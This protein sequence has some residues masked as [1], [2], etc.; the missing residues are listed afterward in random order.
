MTIS[1]PS[2]SSVAA[3]L[4]SLLAVKSAL[5]AARKPPPS[6]A[7]LQ[8]IALGKSYTMQ[9]PPNYRLCTDAGDTVQ[10][11]DGRKIGPDI[12]GKGQQPWVQEAMVGWSRRPEPISITLDLEKEEAISGISFRAAAGGGSITWP[13]Q[14]A[15]FVGQDGEN[16]HFLGD[17]C[18]MSDRVKSA[19]SDGGGF[20]EPVQHEFVTRELQTHA[21]YV[22]LVMAGS[23]FLFC[24]EIEVY[25]GDPDW[26]A[27]PLAGP[28]LKGDAAVKDIV[29]QRRTRAGYESRLSSDRHQ[30]EAGVA[31]SSLP[32][33]EKKRLNAQIAQGY[34]DAMAKELP[35]DDKFR[36]VIPLN[37]AHAAMH[38][39]RGRLWQERVG[40]MTVIEKPHR[41]QWIDFEHQPERAKQTN[42]ALEM[43]GGEFRSEMLLLSNPS[44]AAREVKIEVDGIQGS[45]G[46]LRV[47]SVPWTDTLERT[48]VPTALEQIDFTENQGV[49]SLPAG[50]AT[51]LWLMVDS[52]KL[53]AGKHSGTL[54]LSDAS[55]RQTVPFEVRVSSLVMPKPPMDFYLWDYSAGDPL[56]YGLT[57]NNLAPSI[58]LMREYHVNAPWSAQK[59]FPK[60]TAE[61]FDDQNRLK[62]PLDTSAM[63]QW[64]TKVWPGADRY[65]H[66]MGIDV[67]SKK[68]PTF[69]GVK[70]GDPAFEP[71]IAA[72]LQAITAR[73]EA[74][75]VDP[76]K[77]VINPFDEAKTEDQLRMAS[78]WIAAL[79]KADP[80]VKIFMNP[81]VSS[82]IKTKVRDVADNS[83]I[84]CAHRFSYVREKKPAEAFFANAAA[85]G[86]EFHF[87][88]CSG[89][90][91]ISDPTYYYRL[92][93][94]LAFSQ[95]ATGIGFW[96]F[97]DTGKAASSW[98]E[99]SSLRHS[100][101]PAFLSGDAAIPS[102]HLEALR[103]GIQ[104]YTLLTMLKEASEKHPTNPHAEQ[105][106]EILKA[107]SGL[108]KAG[109][110]VDDVDDQFKGGMWFQKTG[111]LDK[112]DN[113]RLEA[114][115]C[116]ENLQGSDA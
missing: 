18:G 45:P 49:F 88:A 14:I 80:R 28:V 75:G 21:R 110:S 42:V 2:P 89:P 44:E 52:A 114:L 90:V 82:L 74:I 71:R 39:V 73:M 87:Y 54:I 53:P 83:D 60:V 50:V 102:I 78:A 69:A 106:R 25:T 13:G 70:A 107:A 26:K 105:A 32:E 67:Q 5:G 96:S 112:L 94:W 30:L 35:A 113:L 72:W 103:E 9:P 111:P 17:L 64:M 99:Y 16:W 93:S 36:A 79:K 7:P 61:D 33:E 100:Y 20:G 46:W 40:E 84:L 85:K 29:M 58:R 12:K 10:L 4:F 92:T 68:E 98:N 38:A 47:F 86:K 19:P 59:H 57:E 37:D 104:D 97:S 65:I 76:A 24:D 43:L 81:S 1:F 11:T 95:G 41:Y 34:R 22:R 56:F 66:Y 63:E 27:T 51:K 15:I 31:A 23:S 101:T 91:R 6:I 115:R 3:V 116:L 55:G 77:L 108:L 62:T 8:N 48:L 109:E